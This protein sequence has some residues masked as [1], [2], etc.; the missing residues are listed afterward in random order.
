LRERILTAGPDSLAD[1]E[2]LEVILFAASPRADQRP[3]AKALITRFGSFAAVMTAD[4]AA[5]TEVGLSP[6]CVGSIKAA[7]E[8][9]LR[10][11]QADLQER[12][13]VGSWDKLITY[14]AA[15]I[16][17][18]EVEEFHA[19]FLDRKNMLI[20]HE[21]QQ[22]GTTNHV[23]VYPREILKRALALNASAIILVH[24]RPSGDLTPSPTDIAVT[25]AIKMAGKAL[26]LDLYDHIIVAQDAHISLNTLNMI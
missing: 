16:S 14:C 8:A 2:L 17:H 18:I 9:A 20:K 26:G 24:N 11:I 19:L 25:M 21:R 22:R 4:S 3:I 12:P 6:A 15:H 10:V 23:E 1:D 13:V 5:L 7:R